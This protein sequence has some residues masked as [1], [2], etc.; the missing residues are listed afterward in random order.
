MGVAPHTEGRVAPDEKP[1]RH[2]RLKRLG[3]VLLG[4]IV[5]IGSTGAA[6]G[7]TYAAK[8]ATLPQIARQENRLHGGTWVPLRGVSPWFTSALIATEDQSFYSNWG[9]SFEGTLRALLVDIQTGSFAQGGS[10]LTQELIRDLLLS[11][12]KTLERKFIGTMLSFYTAAL[13]SKAQVLTMYVNQVYLGAGA[14]GIQTA[15]MRYFGIPASKLTL[16]EGAMLAGLPQ[17][18]SAYDPLVHLA[19]AK[20]RQKE[21]L[22]RML[23]EGIISSKQARRAYA[24]SLPLR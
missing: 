21:V 17:A 18:P 12:R 20:M 3:F 9:V 8:L 5:V 6:I 10:T 23:A 11:P 1:K 14:Y 2:V 22:D 15:S 7:V 4:L 13:Y 24:A 16:A 19:L